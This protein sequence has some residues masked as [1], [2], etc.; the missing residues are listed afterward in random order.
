MGKGCAAVKGD[1]LFRYLEEGRIV[2]THNERAVPGTSRPHRTNSV[3]IEI[4]HAL[5]RNPCFDALGRTR[6]H[7][8]NLMA[9][10]EFVE[11]HDALF[12]L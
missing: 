8:R 4:G 6:T 12:P 5:M 10:K 2:M 11:I 9:M 3:P 7:E 1:R